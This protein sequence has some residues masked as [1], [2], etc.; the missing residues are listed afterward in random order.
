M[1]AGFAGLILATAA[2]AANACGGDSPSGW[3]GIPDGPLDARAGAAA[4]WSGGEVFVLGGAAVEPCPPDSDC[5]TPPGA[6]LSD[7]AAFDPATGRWRE[8]AAAPTRLGRVTAA[9]LGTQIYVWVPRPGGT[10]QPEV[11]AALLAYDIEHD[12]WEELPLPPS[13]GGYRRLVVAGGDI[14][15]YWR[16]QERGGAHDLLFDVESSSWHEVP[17]DPLTPSFDRFVTWWEGSLIVLGR[18]VDAIRSRDGSSTDYRAAV[19]REGAGVWA[20]LPGSAASG[21]CQEWYRLGDALANPEPA[22]RGGPGAG[23]DPASAAWSPFPPPPED[24]NR[25][26]FD[27]V[28]DGSGHYLLSCSGHVYDARAGEWFEVGGPGG[29]PSEGAAA[30]WAGDQLFL[31][32]GV[33]CDDRICKATDDGWLLDPA[34]AAA[35]RED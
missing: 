5:G 13:T 35:A 18:S 20:Q 2:A 16:S 8:L 28:G 14:L 29:A 17:I 24:W 31:W 27:L 1:R 19:L 3:S 4:V 33:R 12:A 9:A 15:L 26:G 21:G 34:E 11:R 32:G 7:G 25:L 22:R 30:V 23:F 10:G 6:A